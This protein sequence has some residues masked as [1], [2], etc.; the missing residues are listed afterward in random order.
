[1]SASKLNSA[2]LRR[3]AR[4]RLQEAKI[5]LGKKKYDG[6]AYLCGYAIELSL[7]ARISQRL[8]WAEYKTSQDYLSFKTH[9]LAVLLDLSGRD[10]KVKP[11]Y[12]AE[13][14][15][16]DKWKAEFRYEPVGHVSPGDSK[17][18]VEAANVLIGVI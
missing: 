7:K 2:A 11:K 6:A 14:S 13:W 9:K 4:C 18:M 1:M 12:I 3:L 10:K 16:I 17:D 15:V 8:G 5:L